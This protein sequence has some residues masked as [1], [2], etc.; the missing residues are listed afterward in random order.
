LVNPGIIKQF[1]YL[2]DIRGN[3]QMVLHSSS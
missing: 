1:F 2:K 3:R